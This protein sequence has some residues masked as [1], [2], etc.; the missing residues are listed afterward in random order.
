MGKLRFISAFTIICMMI[1]GFATALASQEEITPKI[2]FAQAVSAEAPAEQAPEEAEPL[3]VEYEDLAD[4]EWFSALEGFFS[5]A[6]LFETAASAP[7]KESQD[8]RTLLVDNTT[9]VSLRDFVSLHYPETKFGYDNGK[10]TLS[11]D[12]RYMEFTE[13]N[14][15]YYVDGR[16]LPLSSP[17]FER[18]GCFY[19]PLRALTKIF[20]YDIDWDDESATATLSQNGVRLLSGKEFY[21]QDDYM[22]LAR[23]I[24]A[25]SGNQPLEGKIAVGNVIMNRV[26][27]PSFPNT[28][29]GVIYDRS[30]G[31]QFT[32][33]YNGAMDVYPNEESLIAAKLCLEGYSVTD[34]SLFFFNPD[35]TAARWIRNNRTYVT[36]IGNHAFYS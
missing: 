33:A 15:Y 2:V 35:T 10:V 6:S 32:T 7:Q 17:C 20:S 9:Y 31:V 5:I 30:S 3:F 24:R 26:N 23:L 36:K 13:G 27:N 34:T 14:I 1:S 19:V 25:E 21:D 12:G 28:I 29:S 18:D 22:L 11:C 16:I 4:G 8:M